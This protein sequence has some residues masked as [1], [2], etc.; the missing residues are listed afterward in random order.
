MY[1]S[2]GLGRYSV[3]VRLAFSFMDTASTTT[4]SD[5]AWSDWCRH[6]SFL[7]TWAVSAMASSWC[8]VQLVIGHHYYLCATSIVLSSASRALDTSSWLY[9]P[10]YRPEWPANFGNILIADQ[11]LFLIRFRR[12]DNRSPG[13]SWKQWLVFCCES[14]GWSLY[15]HMSSISSGWSQLYNSWWSG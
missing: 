11:T 10:L 7:A 5:Q 15:V 3:E 6:P 1:L 14:L 9:A 2:L 13:R 8:W 4:T 12:A